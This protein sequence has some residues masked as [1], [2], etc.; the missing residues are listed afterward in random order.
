MKKVKRITLVLLF[1]LIVSTLIVGCSQDK[2]AVEDSVPENDQKDPD[3]SVEA[4]DD[5]TDDV[6]YVE[7]LIVTAAAAPPSLDPNFKPQNAIR[8]FT[9]HIYETL[10]KFDPETKEIVPWLAESWDQPE[11]T[12]YI[13]NIREGVKFHGGEDL[14]AADV[15]YTYERCMD[16]ASAMEYVALI[17]S[18]EIIDDYT[19]K[20]V[21]TEQSPIF[22]GNLCHDI[23]SII[24]ENQGDGIEENPNGTNAYMLVEHKVDDYV[25]L[26]R[27]DNYWGGKKPSKFIRMRIIVDNNSRNLAVEAGDVDIG[28][29]LTN[30]DYSSIKQR[31]DITILEA[32]T[33]VNEFFSMN[34]TEAPFDDVHVRKA[35]AYA[36]NKQIVIDGIYEGDVVNVKSFINPTAFGYD[37]DVDY[38]EYNLEKAKEEMAKSK[39]P[40]GAKFKCYTTSSRGRYTESLQYDLSLIGLDMEVEFVQ[41]VSSAISSGYKGAHITSISYPSYDADAIYRYFHSDTIGDGGN[42]SW[43]SNPVMDELLE[44]SRVEMDSDK[45]FEIFQ[46]IQQILYEE[47]INIPILSRTIK[48]ALNEGVGGFKPSP[49]TIDIFSDAYKIKK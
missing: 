21:V 20:V 2:T 1:I 39:Y 35:V 36:F 31:E 42:L 23:T 28:I 33:I 8:R 5:L 15:K 16:I 6:E 19:L 43:Y 41:N 26:E 13:F 11:P 17:D 40:D 29:Q 10:L 12:V 27:F 3:D 47:A 49:D 32:P 46:D 22:L 45:R 37:P 44:K 38:Y 24:P 9:A 48:V 14:T 4:S 25:L 7:E 18:I 30:A 34:V